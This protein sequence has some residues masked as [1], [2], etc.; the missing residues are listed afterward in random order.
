LQYFA[1]KAGNRFIIEPDIYHHIDFKGEEP[2]DRKMPLLNM[3]RLTDIDSIQ[4][5]FPD[6][7][8][9]IS[10][11]TGDEIRSAFGSYMQKLII[12]ERGMNWVSVLSL[13]KHYISLDEYPAYYDF[14]EGCKKKS[15]NKLVLSQ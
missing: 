15:D 13:D 14:M 10:E 5:I 4:Y 2:K 11:F 7:Y 12:D 1:K 9:L 6:G 8:K 3:S